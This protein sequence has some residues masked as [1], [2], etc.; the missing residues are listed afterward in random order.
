MAFL[1]VFSVHR[2]Q[3]KHLLVALQRMPLLSRVTAKEG[4]KRAQRNPSIHSPH[5]QKQAWLIF[6]KGRLWC[7]TMS[8]CKPWREEGHSLAGRGEEGQLGGLLCTHI[9]VLPPEVHPKNKCPMG[10]SKFFVT[11]IYM[12]SLKQMTFSI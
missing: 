11:L 5:L 1:C 10:A 3:L 7:V 2:R 9:I 12:D 6:A 8:L 4:V